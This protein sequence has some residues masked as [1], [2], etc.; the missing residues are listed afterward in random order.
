MTAAVITGASRGIGRAAALALAQ[1]G[2]DVALLARTERDLADVA[3]IVAR[4]GVTALPVR[5][6][7]TVAGDVSK[8]AARVLE[9]LGAPEVVV[10]NA[11][12]I[13]RAPVHEMSLDDFRLV[14]DTNL[15]GTFLVT[16][17][18]LPAM[19]QQNRGRF[20]Q[21]ASISATLGSP[22]A[23]AYCA[24]KW[25]V[26][27]FTKSLAEELRGTGLVAMSILP[28]SVDTS[29]L[30]G[31]GF[32]PQMTPDDVAKAI[33]YAALDAPSAMNGSSLEMFGP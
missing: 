5:C 6:D 12:V 3:E 18:F 11:G 26:V 30:E 8:A 17:A 31:S 21:M 13:H 27:G 14:V 16:R 1:R 29:M 22:R 32:S 28:G 9:T 19:L 23:S 4:C 25:G 33:V 2:L 10:N 7:V 15:T 24:A 20:V